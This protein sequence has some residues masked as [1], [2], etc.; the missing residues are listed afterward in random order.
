MGDSTP[1]NVGGT[2]ASPGDPENLDR[3]ER[4]DKLFQREG[5]LTAF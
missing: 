5:Q 3:P 4:Y 2:P 1:L